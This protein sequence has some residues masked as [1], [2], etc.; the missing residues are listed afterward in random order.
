MRLMESHSRSIKQNGEFISL[1]S[2]LTLFSTELAYITSCGH[3]VCW[4][5]CAACTWSIGGCVLKAQHQTLAM[6]T[7]SEAAW[8]CCLATCRGQNKR[9]QTTGRDPQQGKCVNSAEQQ[10]L[11][12]AA[13]SQ[14]LCTATRQN[15]DRHLFTNELQ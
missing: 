4:P 7:S 10:Q 9:R 8:K 13:A 14:G 11:C 6:L 12:T 5:V 15:L 2:V 3:T 1:R